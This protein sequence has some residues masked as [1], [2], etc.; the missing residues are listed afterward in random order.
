MIVVCN[1]I[2]IHEDYEE[3]KMKVSIVLDIK[4]IEYKYNLIF[5]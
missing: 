4:T 5:V 3:I 1:E 2:K